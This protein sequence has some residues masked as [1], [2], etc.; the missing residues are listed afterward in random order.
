MS[1]SDLAIF[2]MLLVG[3]TMVAV[4]LER[5]SV[6]MPMVFVLA[7]ALLGPFGLGW[8]TFSVAAPTVERLTEITLALLLFADASTLVFNRAWQDAVLPGRLLLIG[9]PLTVL[10]GGLIAYA[11]FPHENFGFA[12]LLGAILAPTDAAL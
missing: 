9:L 11:L 7:G 10:L 12:L 6:T 2:F 5:F 8:I 1:N 4:R 3:Y